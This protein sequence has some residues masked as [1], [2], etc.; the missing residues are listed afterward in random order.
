MIAVP[1][2][3]LRDGSAAIDVFILLLRCHAAWGS[4]TAC[5]RTAGTA[6]TRRRGTAGAAA[7]RTIRSASAARTTGSTG[8]TGAAIACTRGRRAGCAV[9]GFFRLRMHLLFLGMRRT[10][11][12]ACSA[13]ITA[14]AC[15]WSS[16]GLCLRQHLCMLF[17]GC[18]LLWIGAFAYPLVLGEGSA[19]KRQGRNQD[20]YGLVLQ[21][22][23][24][25]RLWKK[26]DRQWRASLDCT[27]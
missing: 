21:D 8:T 4:R 9:R 11:G 3:R 22:V 23:L 2:C 16:V 18:N 7:G 17:Y 5:A 15:S 25:V 1:S 14:R 13:G 20:G 26:L 10:G 24:L 12:G 19:G 27:M 6:G